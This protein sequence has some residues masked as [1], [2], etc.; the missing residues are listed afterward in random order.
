MLLPEVPGELYHCK[1]GFVGM[2]VRFVVVVVVVVV[3][4]EGCHC[5]A[6]KNQHGMRA[7]A[8]VSLFLFLSFLRLVLSGAH[9]RRSRLVGCCHEVQF[10]L[11]PSVKVCGKSHQDCA[12]LSPPDPTP[13]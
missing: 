9:H 1:L 10:V 3:V 8:S 2:L 13:G 4:L 5:T 11:V 7:R 12:Q 6:I